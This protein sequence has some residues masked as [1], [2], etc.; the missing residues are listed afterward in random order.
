MAI[1]SGKITD[2]GLA[3]ISGLTPQAWVQ[4]VN[5]AFGPAGEFLAATRKPLTVNSTTGIYTVS[6]VPSLHCSP[7]TDYII[8]VT[9][10]EANGTP[11]GES[12]LR[13]TA[14]VGGGSPGDMTGEPVFRFY[15][16]P[17]A[18]ASPDTGNI[19]LDSSEPW[20]YQFKR[21]SGMSW[22][23]VGAPIEGPPGTIDAGTITMLPAGAA[24]VF[25]VTGTPGNR[26]ADLGIP[27][28]DAEPGLESITVSGTR[29][30]AV[31]TGRTY[32]I[33]GTGVVTLT[34]VLG[35]MPN[36]QLT[37]PMRVEGFSLAAGMWVGHNSLDG[38]RFREAAAPAV[39]DIV[40]PTPGALAA[41]LMDTSGLLRVTN[42]TDDVVLHASPYRFSTNNGST[43]SAWQASASFELSSLTA[44][45][46]YVFKHQTRDAASNVATG[47][48]VTATTAAA[49][50]WTTR[51]YDTFTAADGTALA[52]RTPDTGTAW[53]ATPSGTGTVIRGN[54]ASGTGLNNTS[55]SALWPNGSAV[56]QRVR[57]TFDYSLPISPPYGA[58]VSPYQ[59]IN[60]ANNN[61]FFI[62]LTQ[63]NAGVKSV[64]MSMFGGGAT[65]SAVQLTTAIPESGTFTFD[66]LPTRRVGVV[67]VGSTV[68]GYFSGGADLSWYGMNMAIINNATMDNLRVEV[69][70]T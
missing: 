66:Y 37:V 21:W 7:P 18:P 55:T 30:I 52:G 63:S 23:S 47:S 45:T 8:G 29:T 19:W 58:T 48:A 17:T 50:T 26:V 4:A 39:G 5:E 60:A 3:P 51:M 56:T 67:K 11:R 49:P 44:G 61:Y 22:I 15:N 10:L 6:L 1:Y 13:F 68:I 46:E 24:P 64:S 31:I 36:L 69:S 38:W 65:W 41:T 12:S 43:W 40:A 53:G 62:S 32:V 34:G 42:A 20:S 59:G 14:A 35:A 54:K 28:R 25:N 16:G 33:S 2:F 57:V 9:W 70:S 27:Q